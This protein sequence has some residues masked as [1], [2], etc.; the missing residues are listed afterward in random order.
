MRQEHILL[1][2]GPHFCCL[3][4]HD[5]IGSS[6]GGGLGGGAG[7]ISAWRGQESGT[8]APGQG[9]APNPPGQPAGPTAESRAGRDQGASSYASLCRSSVTTR[10]LCR[11]RH[12]S[13]GTRRPYCL[14]GPAGGRVRQAGILRNCLAMRSLSF[15]VTDSAGKGLILSL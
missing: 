14:A 10:R 15:L 6:P 13:R 7:D 5:Q 12:G 2:G 9:P 3:G 1:R 8:G 4:R 11:H